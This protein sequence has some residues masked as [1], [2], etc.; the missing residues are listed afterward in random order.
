MICFSVG[1]GFRKQ[2]QVEGQRRGVFEGWMEAA[3]WRK[4]IKQEKPTAWR[5]HES[6]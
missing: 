6:S 5:S 1:K 2:R 4:P 3:G